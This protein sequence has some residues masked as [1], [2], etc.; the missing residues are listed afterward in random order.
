MR[1]RALPPAPLHCAATRPTCQQTAGDARVQPG[2]S[3]LLLLLLLLLAAAAAAAAAAASCCE[4]H[5]KL[6]HHAA[7]LVLQRLGQPLRGHCCLS[8]RAVPALQLLCLNL[9]SCCAHGLPCPAR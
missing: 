6:A 3:R 9:H 5:L 2:S 7:E 1:Q 8:G 4:T